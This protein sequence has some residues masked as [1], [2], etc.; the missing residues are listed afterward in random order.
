MSESKSKKSLGLIQKRQKK[1]KVSAKFLQYQVWVNEEELNSNLLN[2]FKA[3][4]KSPLLREG[5]L[6]FSLGPD[7]IVFQSGRI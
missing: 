4:T 3:S 7:F 1:K 2:V 5:N 6:E